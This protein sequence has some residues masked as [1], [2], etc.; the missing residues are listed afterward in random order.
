MMVGTVLSW[1]I[2]GAFVGI[3]LDQRTRAYEQRKRDALVRRLK[4]RIAAG[5]IDAQLARSVLHDL[6]LSPL[7]E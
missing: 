2:L 1:L 6:S 5:G 3:F 4:A 7:D